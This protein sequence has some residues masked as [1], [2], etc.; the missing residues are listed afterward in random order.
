MKRKVIITALPE[1]ETGMQ[2]KMNGL[3]AGLGLNARVMGWPLEAGKLSEPEVSV[4]STL[5]PVPRHQAN[6]EAEKGEIAM[7]PGKGGIPDTFKIGGQRHHSGGTPL[8]LPADSFIYSDT[9]SMKIKDENILSQFGMS[10]RPGGYTPADIAKKYNI[11]K[12][13][14]VLVDP[15]TDDLQRDTAEGMI[16]NYNLKLAKLALL[17]ESKKGFPQGIPVVAMPY[18]ESMGI[19]PAQFTQMNPQ[20]GQTQT[21]ADTD[22][23]G[24]YGVIVKAQN[25]YQ[26]LPAKRI[27][28]YDY[29]AWGKSK[30]TPES[31]HPGFGPRGGQ[32]TLGDVLQESKFAKTYPDY[33]QAYIK[34]LNST[35]ENEIRQI[36]ESLGSYDVPYSLNLPGTDQ[37]KFS[38]LSAIL[39]EKI[40]PKVKAAPT[41]QELDRKTAQEAEQTYNNIYSYY[42]NAEPGS[43]QKLT[44]KKVLDEFSQYHPSYRKDNPA[45]SGLHKESEGQFLY[46]DADKAAIRSY[47]QTFNKMLTTKKDFT[48]P[49]KEVAPATGSTTN[50]LAA[51]AKPAETDYDKMS[52]AELLKLLNQ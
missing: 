46:D 11:N 2:V 9:K 37:N 40:T 10:Y 25:G 8:N 7:L 36:S 30:V 6:L 52:D 16:A 13:K 22:Q 39:R 17:Q 45:I 41:K 29:R 34:A 19:D 47:Y 3:K 18:I 42:K 20:G 44:F 27:T 28:D 24:K 1:A 48:K 50:Q 15:N 14:K 33:Y 43:N 23:M 32:P 5:Q 12:F 49:V 4:N 38:D 35:D 51:T 26:A 21:S 31:I